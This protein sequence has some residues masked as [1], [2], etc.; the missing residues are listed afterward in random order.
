MSD[1]DVRYF[2]QIEHFLEKTIE[3]NPLPEGLGEGPEYKAA[4]K[5]SGRRRGR[6]GKGRSQRGGGKGNRNR[7]KRGQGKSNGKAA[8]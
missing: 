4:A 5:P 1:R 2:Q 7:K 6:G 8:S 3:K